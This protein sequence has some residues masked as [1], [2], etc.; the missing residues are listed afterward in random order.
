VAR[1]STIIAFIK[2]ML[3]EQDDSIFYFFHKLNI[4]C[5]AIQRLIS[6]FYGTQIDDKLF[7]FQIS[8][9]LIF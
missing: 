3:L 5:G 7:K 1:E 4:L 6:Q 8:F 9:N 2:L